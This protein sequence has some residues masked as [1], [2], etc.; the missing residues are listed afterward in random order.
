LLCFISALNFFQVCLLITFP[1]LDLSQDD[2]QV[3]QTKHTKIVLIF[4]ERCGFSLGFISL[5]KKTNKKKCFRECPSY[6]IVT[7]LDSLDV[8]LGMCNDPDE[9]YCKK[10]INIIL[11]INILI[12]IIII[13]VIVIKIIIMNI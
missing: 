10:Y 7:N 4:P 5:E 12:I 8:V 13:I 6:E 3:Y 9:D 2:D 1:L 11:I